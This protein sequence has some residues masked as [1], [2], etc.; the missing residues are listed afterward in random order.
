MMVTLKESRII[1]YFLALLFIPLIWV[2]WGSASKILN[3]VLLHPDDYVIE[4]AALTKNSCKKYGGGVT[5]NISYNNANIDGRDGCVLWADKGDVVKVYFNK[6]DLYDNGV[7]SNLINLFVG[8]LVLLL[9]LTWY[10]I[11]RLITYGN[12]R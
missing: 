5:F 7:W 8:Q 12:Q 9:L 3:V 6:Q 10:F 1:L 4:Q 11:K 2:C